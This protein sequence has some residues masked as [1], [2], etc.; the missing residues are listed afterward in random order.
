M[1][2]VKG[3]LH[4]H[5]YVLHA[6]GIDGRWID[7]LCTKVA[8]LHRFHVAQLVDGIGGLDN[9]WVGC[10]EPVDVGP[11]LQHLSIERCCDDGCG[12]VAAAPSQVGRLMAVAIAADEAW[13]HADAVP[14]KLRFLFFEKRF[15][16]KP[17]GQFAVE[18]MLSIFLFCADEVATVHALGTTNECCHNIRTQALAIGHNGIQRLLAQV[19]NEE[20]TEIDRTQLFQQCVHLVK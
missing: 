4:L 8:Q 10:H 20:D 12:V 7:D 9:A 17:I 16:D 6:Y 14:E 5:R 15:P 18:N 11:Y 2:G 19:V 1:V 3:V 13:H